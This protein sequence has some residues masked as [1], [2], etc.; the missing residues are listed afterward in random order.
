[1]SGRGVCG[2]HNRLSQRTL[3][4]NQGAVPCLDA[5]CFVALGGRVEERAAA[6][7]PVERARVASHV[8]PPFQLLGLPCWEGRRGARPSGRALRSRRARLRKGASRSLAA[9]PPPGPPDS[10]GGPAPARMV[11]YHAPGDVPQLAASNWHCEG[12]A[13]APGKDCA[14][15]AGSGTRPC[16]R[17][18]GPTGQRLA[19]VCCCCS[20]SRAQVRAWSASRPQ[21]RAALCSVV[22]RMAIV[23]R[24]HNLLE[25]SSLEPR[26]HS[27]QHCAGHWSLPMPCLAFLSLRTLH[28][29]CAATK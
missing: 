2:D 5:L 20:P 4:H 29:F 26:A 22:V 9:L 16:L 1:M 8:Q 13:S 6:A 28:R 7:L 21:G 25:S 11:R 10:D 17:R 19:A 3:L 24:V 12:R 23:Q 15:R 27:S 18:R 14:A